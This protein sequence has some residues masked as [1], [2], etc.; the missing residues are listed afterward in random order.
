MRPP[1][2]CV[3]WDENGEHCLSSLLLGARCC[4]HGDC[5]L[6]EADQE[7]MRRAGRHELEVARAWLQGRLLRPARCPSCGL[8]PPPAWTDVPPLPR[9]DRPESALTGT[10]RC[11]YCDRKLLAV[12]RKYCDE[13]CWKAYVAWSRGLER[14]WVARA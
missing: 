3:A 7:R 2:P 8:P 5:A 4:P 9:L 1:F 13:D 12:R 6:C 11:L 14:Q 10:S